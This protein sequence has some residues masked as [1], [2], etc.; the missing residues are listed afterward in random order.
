MAE[1]LARFTDAT[2]QDLKVRAKYEQLRFLEFLA[3]KGRLPKNISK[4]DLPLR[5]RRF[6]D[7]FVTKGFLTLTADIRHLK[8][9]LR[10]RDTQQITVTP[11]CGC[12]SPILPPV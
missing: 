7:R 12:L 4:A 5:F 9:D 3:E 8:A 6:F 10:P 11:V 2:I 1:W